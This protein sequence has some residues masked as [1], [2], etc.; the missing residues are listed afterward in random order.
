MIFDSASV[1]AYSFGLVVLFFLCRIFAKPIKWL[2]KLII[3]GVLGGLILA[4]VNFVGGF[5]GIF[6]A[7][8]P[9]TALIAGLLGVPGVIL[10]ILLQYI[11]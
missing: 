8:N 11:L 10:V 5:A 1:I 7:I 9:L 2:L 4:A 6:I 3:N